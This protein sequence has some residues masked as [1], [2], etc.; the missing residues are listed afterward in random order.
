[1]S[2]QGMNDATQKQDFSVNTKSAEVD[3][4][5]NHAL[6]ELAGFLTTLVRRYGY[7]DSQIATVQTT[8]KNFVDAFVPA[9]VR[10]SRPVI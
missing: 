2:E 6:A 4:L 1:M 9:N 8:L 5:E 7:T 10:I 3:M